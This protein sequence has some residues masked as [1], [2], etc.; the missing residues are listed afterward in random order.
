ML[1]TGA[2]L[3][4]YICVRVYFYSLINSWQVVWRLH[5][6]GSNYVGFAT[7][8]TNFK[9]GTMQ[10]PIFIITSH[11]QALVFVG[12]HAHSASLISFI[13]RNFGFLYLSTRRSLQY[14]ICHV[15]GVVDC[16]QDKPAHSFFVF[17]LIFLIFCSGCYCLY[18]I[19]RSWRNRQNRKLRQCENQQQKITLVRCGS[20]V[21]CQH[22]RQ[23]SR[24]QCARHTHFR[25]VF[26]IWFGNCLHRHAGQ[27][28]FK[29]INAT[30]I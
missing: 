17:L 25:S 29:K 9:S 22:C 8:V 26:S 11:N 24:N 21:W 28:T 1:N 18:Q 5:R 16:V 23:L 3:S 27:R 4:K 2:V 6:L 19:Q 12:G 15:C 13:T 30:V 14:C 10:K 7:E 20:F